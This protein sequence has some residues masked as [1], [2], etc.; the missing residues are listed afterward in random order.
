MVAAYTA[1]ASVSDVVACAVHCLDIFVTF[2][3]TG[4]AMERVK[5]Q[6]EELLSTEHMKVL[7]QQ[8]LEALG[9]DGEVRIADCA[10]VGPSLYWSPLSTGCVQ[11]LHVAPPPSRLQTA[12]ALPTCTGGGDTP[13]RQKVD[14]EV[15][16][17]TAEAAGEQVKLV[18]DCT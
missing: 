7:N 16:V 18:V 10:S 17:C 15:F 6:L 2:N 9:S 13:K 1:I 11:T 5:V 12:A 4:P 8:A 3:W 14:I